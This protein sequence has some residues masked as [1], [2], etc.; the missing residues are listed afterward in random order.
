[1][2]N[3][4]YLPTSRNGTKAGSLNIVF[5]FWSL[6]QRGMD[7]QDLGILARAWLGQVKICLFAGQELVGKR[8]LASHVYNVQR[9]N[10]GMELYLS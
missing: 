3:P 1:L 10:E 6:W 4:P 9:S 5:F 7:T 8:A 2:L